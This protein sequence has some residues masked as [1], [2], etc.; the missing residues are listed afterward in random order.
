MLTHEPST[1]SEECEKIETGGGLCSLLSLVSLVVFSRAAGE[2]TR[3]G[4]NTAATDAAEARERETHTDRLACAAAATVA[5]R[6]PNIGAYLR[7]HQ[8]HSFLP[9][10]LLPCI[11]RVCCVSS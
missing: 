3:E 8:E 7:R 9:T 2:A 4:R 6:R 10:C 1:D 5:A 11:N